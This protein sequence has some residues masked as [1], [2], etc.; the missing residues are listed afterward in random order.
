MIFNLTEFLTKDKVT[1]T[2]LPKIG[3]YNESF[4]ANELINLK[5]RFDEE[6]SDAFHPCPPN[7]NDFKQFNFSSNTKMDFEKIMPDGDY[8]Y[9]HKAWNDDDENVFTKIVYERFK[10]GEDSFF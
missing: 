1:K 5:G 6:G 4:V 2:K 7:R 10:T 3:V 9:E 8:R